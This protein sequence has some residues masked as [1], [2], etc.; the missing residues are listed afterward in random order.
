M[1]AVRLLCRRRLLEPRQVVFQVDLL[2]QQAQVQEQQD[3]VSQPVSS[4]IVDILQ[5][6]AYGLCCFWFLAC[7]WDRSTNQHV[8]M[9]LSF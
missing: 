4:R 7:T 9:I 8:L 3:P 5:E 2:H 6:L 1:Q